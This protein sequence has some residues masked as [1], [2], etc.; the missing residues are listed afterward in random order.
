MLIKTMQKRK[1]NKHYE[2]N[3]TLLSR[4]FITLPS[5][6][7]GEVASTSPSECNFIC[8]YLSFV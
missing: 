8:E 7:K 4:V 2:V 6:K 1:I 5:R 3:Q